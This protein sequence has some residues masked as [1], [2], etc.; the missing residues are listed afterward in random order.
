MEKLNNNFFHLDLTK[1][2]NLKM[3]SYW[4]KIYKGISYGNE[5]EIRH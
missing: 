2:L 5:T 1:N 4:Q 3:P